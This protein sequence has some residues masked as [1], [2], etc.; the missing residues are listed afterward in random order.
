MQ[1]ESR[2]TKEKVPEPIKSDTPIPNHF[3]IQGLNYV[4]EAGSF[5]IL[6]PELAQIAIYSIK[7]LKDIEEGKE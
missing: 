6:V 1:K 5:N 4:C 3:K 7:C 2:L